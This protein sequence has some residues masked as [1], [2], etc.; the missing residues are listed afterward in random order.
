MNG[1]QKEMEVTEIE[2]ETEKLL[3][4]VGAVY[5]NGLVKLE[6]GKEIGARVLAAA[7]KY[8]EK[9]GQIKFVWMRGERLAVEE[10]KVTVIGEGGGKYVEAMVDRRIFDKIAAEVIDWSPGGQYPTVDDRTL[11]IT[12]GL[13]AA[14]GMEA[15]IKGWEMVAKMVGQIYAEYVKI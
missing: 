11:Y 1:V 8:G 2:P 6:S 15:K 7:L 5:K 4:L 12:G 10:P 9:K 14:R 3:N 13:L